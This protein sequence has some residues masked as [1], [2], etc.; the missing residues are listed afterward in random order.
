MRARA[1]RTIACIHGAALR[2]LLGLLL[3]AALVP[4]QAQSLAPLQSGQLPSLHGSV[5]VRSIAVID[6]RPLAMSDAAAW[7]LDRLGRHWIRLPWPAGAQP[8]AGIIGDGNQAWLLTTAPGAHAVSGV[9]RVHASD[10]ALQLQALPDLPVALRDAH[11]AWADNLLSIAGI[12]ADGKA[13]VLQLQT[14][15]GQARW[16]ALPGW[17]G[18]GAP[19]SLV[20][21]AGALFITVPEASGG[22]ERLW[23]RNA[24]GWSERGQVPGRVLPGSGHALGQA[25]ALY[26]VGDGA[27]AA[28]PARLMTFQTITSAWAT[29][30]GAAPAGVVAVGAWTDGMF[31]AQ[32]NAGGTQVAFGYASV[33]SSKLLLRWLDWAVIAIYLVG[34]IGIGL[35]FYLRE[36]RNST[37]SFFVGGRSIPFW[38]VGVSLY[39]TNTSSISF[40]AIPAKAFETNWQYLTNNLIAVLGLMFVAVWIVP[41]LRRLDLM[42]VFSYL[43]TRFHP[44][45]RMLASALCIVMQIGSRMSVILFLPAL[46]IA[47]ITGIDVVWSVLIMGVFT[48]LYTTLGGMKAVIWTDFVQVFVMFGGALFAIGF[49]ISHIHGGVPAFF[50]AAMA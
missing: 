1:D 47:T 28:A 8:A 31:W 30:P 21:R 37:A 48:I 36:K 19:S 7:R 12:G 44:A 45:I 41:L 22:R 18:D 13:H 2:V 11:G 33:Q 39:A 17:P 42:S 27:H 10:D 16:R 43:E 15:L 34:M 9:A 50:H 4:A 3:I 25:N 14:D 32:P 6:G 24:D 20:A 40:I 29:L 35:Y 38:A 23:R 5:A 49:I 26:L 46:A